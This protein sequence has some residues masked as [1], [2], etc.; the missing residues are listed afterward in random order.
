[1]PYLQP[2]KG[3]S[4]RHSCPSCGQAQSF[5]LYLND[6]THEPINSKVGKCN[7]EIK[8]G[9]HYPP[10]QYFIDNPT[11]RDVACHVSN[12]NPIDPIQPPRPIGTIPFSF[13]QNSFSPNSH[14]VSFLKNHFPEDKIKAVCE[15]YYLGATK[16]QE[17]IFW[18]VD[19]KGKIRTGKI[20]QYN[21]RTGKRIKHKSG[22]INWVHNKLKQAKQLP[23][24]FNLRQ[25]FF[26]EHLLTIYPTA[27]VAIVESE[28]TAII[29]AMLLPEYCW[30]AAGSLNGLSIE[31]CAVLK[32]HSVILFPDHGAYEKWSTKAKEIEQYIN[33][34]FSV[35]SL[36]QNTTIHTINGLDIADFLI[37]S[38]PL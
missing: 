20:M 19:T 7:R 17:V 5:T 33:V 25:C 10:R 2:Y 9:Y 35:S 12:T 37:T 6:H 1:M 18:Q 36:L 21:P 26:G 22:A 31:K 4:T 14:F 24:D 16:N 13:V 28:K 15:K 32:S 8:C 27:T 23:A 3:R 38:N 29:A 30:L 11:C 34:F